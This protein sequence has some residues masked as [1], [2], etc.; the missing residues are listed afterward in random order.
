MEEIK[1]KGIVLKCSDFKDN[2]RLINVFCAELGVIAVKVR[3][4]KKNGAKLAFAVQPFAF[5]EFLLAKNG[6]FYTCINASSIDQ[7]FDITAD[8]DNYIFMLACM[9][10]CLKTV[11]ESDSSPK[12]FLLLLNC[13]KAVCYE[14][15][16][17]MLV[18]IKF[19]IEALKILGFSMEITKCSCCGNSL[20]NKN[21][22]FSYE[23]NGLLCENCTGKMLNLELSAG[24][25][26]ILRFINMTSLENLS[27]LKFSS[28]DDLVSV[29][30]LLAKDFRVI[31][32]QEIETLKKF[33]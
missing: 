8:F 26:S 4:V 22:G 6:G 23:F 28:R 17:V 13:F 11:K 20:K 14:K 16:N 12:L 7:F 31:F 5:V 25:Y 1:V 33:L 15:I 21:V 29:I 32:E 24:E 27:N 3:G 10:V 30:S 18:F 19:M 9:E 2:D